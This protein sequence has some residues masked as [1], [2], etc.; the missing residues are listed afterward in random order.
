[1]ESITSSSEDHGRPIPGL[2]VERLCKSAL[3]LI[4]NV[5]DGSVSIGI[6]TI[7]LMSGLERA[8]SVIF[9]LEKFM[10][11]WWFRLLSYIHLL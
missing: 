1:M 2:L 7:T 11:T 10:R 3:K 9:N 4:Y 6:S 8:W 5:A